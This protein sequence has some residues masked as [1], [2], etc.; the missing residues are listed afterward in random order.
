VVSFRLGRIDRGTA[1]RH[2]EFTANVV[3]HGTRVR[4]R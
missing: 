1:A 4:R 3:A 2:I